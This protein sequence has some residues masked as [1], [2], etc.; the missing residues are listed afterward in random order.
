MK[1][2]YPLKQLEMPLEVV[3]RDGPFTVFKKDASFVTVTL[4]DGKKIN[5]VLLLYPNYVIA[6]EGETK[7]SFSPSNVTEVAQTEED[8]VKKSTSDWSFFYNLEEF[9]ERG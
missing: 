3:E 8:L 1:N 6:V 7:L 2:T 4:S 9:S 5:G